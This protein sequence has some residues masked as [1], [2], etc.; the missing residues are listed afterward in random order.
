[1][2]FYSFRKLEKARIR[3]LINSF[4]AISLGR[5]AI[6]GGLGALFVAGDYFFFRRMLGYMAHLP[7]EVGE[8]LIIQLLNLLC[9]TFFSMLVFS[10]IITAISTL[11]MSRDLD[12]LMS[13]P[14]PV[15]GVFGSK[16]LITLIN[17]SWMAALFGIPIFVA[18]GEVYFAPWEYYA[19][20]MAAF[21]PFLLIPSAMGILV[22]MA[23]MRFFPARRI[24]QI[25]SFV[26]LVFIAGLVM[27]FRFLQPEKFLGK[28]DI[29]EQEILA[30]VKKLEAPE[31][32]WLPSSMLARAL[33]A[34]ARGEWDVFWTQ[35]AW[36]WILAASAMAVMAVAAWR[37]YYQ[38]WALSQGAREQGAPKEDRIFYRVTKR[39]LRKAPG[40]ARGII[41]KD[42]KIFWRDTGQWSQLF[43]LAAL[44]IVYIFNIRNLPLDT[45]FLK[46]IVSVMNIGLAGVVLAAVAARF[47][48][49]TTSVEGRSFWSLHSAPVDF[50]VFLWSKF[51]LYLFPLA[52]L[53]EI[54][55]VVSN[56]LL[57]VDRFVMTVSAASIMAMTVAITG[58]GVGMGAMYP[59]FD[60]E[61]IAEVGVTTGAIIYMIISMAYIGVAV[62][63]VSGP[64]YSHL[65]KIYLGRETGSIA[66]WASYAG[67]LF[68]SGVLTII[69]MRMG[70]AAL[71]KMES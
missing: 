24:H 54:L 64:V 20:F 37:L 49:P 56:I 14:M 22:T 5:L 55:V 50:R 33:Q 18:Y 12:L 71:R 66:I 52:A 16:G 47:V 41:L 59:K 40:E 1:M 30:F 61:N 34:S 53:A 2:L 36:L 51:F 6:L 46:N 42:V 65:A 11:F 25:F 68:T 21:A 57:G 27:F 9:L 3:L 19:I 8:I 60:Y 10:N 13:S 29:P 23:L 26:G 44:I 58:L 43:M 62:M 7:F 15:M 67:V 45:L 69:P 70:V 39:L 48:F 38:A 32:E 17:S 4:R 28:K 31:H 63:F 35:S